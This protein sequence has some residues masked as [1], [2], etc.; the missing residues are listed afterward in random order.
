M[1]FF[2]FIWKCVHTCQVWH[3]TWNAYSVFVAWV[4][5]ILECLVYQSHVLV[6]T[7]SRSVVSNSLP[8]HRLQPT[9][10]FWLWNSP[11]KNTGEG[12]HSLLQ[13]IFSTQRLKLGL[14]HCRQVLYHLSHVHVHQSGNSMNSQ[15]CDTSHHGSLLKNIYFIIIFGCIG[16]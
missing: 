7:L 14:L 9:R 3:L 12:T 4:K 15:N 11:G 10:L 13:R 8:P 5:D 16:F 2:I 1:Q 6:L